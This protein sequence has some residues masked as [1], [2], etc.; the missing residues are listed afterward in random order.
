M[1]N[2][3]LIQWIL[4]IIG[5]ILVIV[6]FVKGRSGFYL[7]EVPLLLGI[8]VV[9]GILLYIARKIKPP[10]SDP[11]S[12]EG[13]WSASDGSTKVFGSNGLCQ[14]MMAGPIGGPQTYV[15]SG[16]KDSN[17]HYALLISQ[18]PNKR[19]LY[20][21]DSGENKVNVFDNSGNLLWTMTKKK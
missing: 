18:P 5:G 6:V 13:M 14:N 9:G 20:V 3:K 11:L 10:S 21:N 8:L 16:T 17:G 12:L 4:I 1:N 15:L 2:K 7:S 19:T